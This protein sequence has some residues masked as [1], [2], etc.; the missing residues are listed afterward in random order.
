MKKVSCI[1]VSFNVRELLKDCLESLRVEREH[2]SIEIVIVDNASS[3]GSP[4]MLSEL[5]KEDSDLRIVLNAENVGFAAACNQ[6]ADLA[7]GD[8][9]IFLNPDT[10]VPAGT[11]KGMLDFIAADP[12]VGI[13]GPRIEYPDGSLQFSCGEEL[14]LRYSFFEAFRLWTVS[15]RLFGGGRYMSWRHDEVRDVGWVSGGCLMIRRTL[16][17][18]LHGF[19]ETFFLYTED[20][21]LCLRA[22]RMGRRVVY[23]PNARILHSEAK[24]A[25]QLRGDSLVRRY[26]ARLYY[27]KKHHGIGS[28]LLLRL[29]FFA[30]S[31]AE[32]I[33]VG[34]AALLRRDGAYLDIMRAH[35]AAAIRV[36]FLSV[37]SPSRGKDADSSGN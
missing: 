25:V 5:G 32:S 34:V 17:R 36:L 19:D 10:I 28:S 27:F 16:F 1:I 18:E 12:D 15:P 11:T 13:V 6:G 33:V 31:L 29:I 2:L 30:S 24:S 23:W 14:D 9:L 8:I 21:D 37:P 22:K 3:D 4:E 35:L 7:E 26:R 20:M